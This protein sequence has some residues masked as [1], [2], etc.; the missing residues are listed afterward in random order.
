[1]ISTTILTKLLAVLAFLWLATLVSCQTTDPEAIPSGSIFDAQGTYR[2]YLAIGNDTIQ[3]IDVVLKL[4]SNIE[5]RVGSPSDLITPFGCNLED[6]AGVVQQSDDGSPWYLTVNMNESPPR[7]SI[8]SI[9]T[10]KYF[11]GVRLY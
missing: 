2:G 4:Y 9:T 5:M 6:N 11:F 10:D 1:M 7:M 8:V 3:D